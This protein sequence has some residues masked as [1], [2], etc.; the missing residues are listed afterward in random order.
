MF[1]KKNIIIV[2]YFSIKLL[3]FILSTWLIL[4]GI[5]SVIDFSDLYSKARDKEN[6]GIGNLIIIIILMFIVYM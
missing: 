3:K 5:I 4:I 1:F 2:K 6:I